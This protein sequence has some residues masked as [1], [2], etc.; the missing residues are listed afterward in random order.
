MQKKTILTVEDNPDDEVLIMRALKTSNL[1]GE[2]VVAR[3]GAEALDYL[4]G[5]GEYDDRDTD[6]TPQLI[7]LDLKLPKVDGLEVLRRI[8]S[9]D[10][11]RVLPVAV[12]TSSSEQE[13]M[14]ESYRLGLNSYTRKSVNFDQF[15][16]SIRLVVLY[17][18]YLNQVPP[19]DP[20]GLGQKTGPA[21]ETRPQGQTTPQ[22]K[23]V[24]KEQTTPE[25]KTGIDEEPGIEEEAGIQEQ[26][27]IEE[28]PGIEE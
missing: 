15:T 24:D 20:V 6:V 9:D 25:A 8:R 2:V 3:D 21:E 13:D 28:K 19:E 7:L 16:E 12:L 10:R 18:M 23:A 26:P 4:F 22:V 11:T 1:A 14:I 17:W 5:T 27:G